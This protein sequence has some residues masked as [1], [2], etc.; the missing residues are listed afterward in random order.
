MLRLAAFVLILGSLLC[1]AAAP[2]APQ[3]YESLDAVLWMQTSVEYRA[4]A[5]ETYAAAKP[6][7]LR[8]LADK[9]WTA[10]T[11]QTGDYSNLPPAV[12]LDLDETVLDNSPFEADMLAGTTDAS[13]AGISDMKGKWEDWMKQERAGLVPGAFDFLVFAQTHGVT[14]VYI[15]NRTCDSSSATDP[16]V[17]MLHKLRLP[18]DPSSQHLFCADNSTGSD[19]TSR[20][21][22]VALKFR[23]LLL[24]GD[25]L[26][27]FIK[28][29][30]DVAARTQLFDSYRSMWGDRWFQ[31]PNPT[32]GN[33]LDILGKTTEQRL[34]QL[35]K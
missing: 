35:R 8:A 28:D 17:S 18:L 33:W 7:L 19:K 27:D 29:P 20:R 15:T 9:G 22:A 11:E 6:A 3:T 23:V 26:G 12:V 1:A 5:V 4:A 13:T 21:A 2:T 25:Q 24:F 10:A 32:Y 30:G 31:L 14:P 34:T 16:T